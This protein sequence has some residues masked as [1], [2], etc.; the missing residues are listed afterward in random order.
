MTRRLILATFATF[1]FAHNAQ[2]G[3]MALSVFGGGVL[4]VTSRR[5][6]QRAASRGCS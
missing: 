6:G 2:V 5:S 3:F 1:L 4:G